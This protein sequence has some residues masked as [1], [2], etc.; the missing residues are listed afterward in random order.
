M[1]KKT[2]FKNLYYY[3]IFYQLLKIWIFFGE[4]EEGSKHL[5]HCLSMSSLDATESL[6]LVL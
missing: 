4:V 6:I 3:E 2:Y 1:Q 5:K